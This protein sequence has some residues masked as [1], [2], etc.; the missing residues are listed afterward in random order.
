[1]QDNKEIESTDIEGLKINDRLVDEY[2]RAIITISLNP[3]MES[4]S[5][6]MITICL[7]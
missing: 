4:I 7:Q 2:K 6:I 1:M 3:T 5:S